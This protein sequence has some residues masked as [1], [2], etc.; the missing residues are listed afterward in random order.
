MSDSAGAVCPDCDGAL[1]ESSSERG[2][3]FCP[4]CTT[5]V[6]TSNACYLCRECGEVEV[7]HGNWKCA[8]CREAFSNE[9]GSPSDQSISDD[10]AGDDSFLDEIAPRDCSGCGV[11][12]MPF[13]LI[14]RPL[15]DGDGNYYVGHRCP[16]CGEIIE[17]S[18]PASGEDLASHAKEDAVLDANPPEDLGELNSV[19][20]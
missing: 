19:E 8:D 6:S 5:P 12:L 4:N 2:D 20:L 10:D 9:D 18:R 1:S 15:H 11:P 7:P 3:Y 17:R 13:N 14:F 16:H